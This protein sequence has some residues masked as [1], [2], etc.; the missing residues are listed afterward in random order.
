MNVAVIGTG[1]VG[2]VTGT[3]FAEFGINVTCVDKDEGKIARL[4]AGEIPIFEPGLEELVRR[5]HKS[6]RL[7]FTTDVRA[8][9]QSSLV[10]FI[11][12]ATPPQADGSTDLSFVDQVSRTIGHTK[13]GVFWCLFASQEGPPLARVWVTWL[14]TE[15]GG[16]P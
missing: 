13:T 12:V 15:T 10:I 5:G 2:L 1:Y 9:V 3:C 4:N 16:S 8:A 11:A 14:R 7:Q 6:G